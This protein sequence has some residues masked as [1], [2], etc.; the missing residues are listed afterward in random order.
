MFEGPE[1]LPPTRV[2]RSSAGEAERGRRE[3]AQVDSQGKGFQVVEALQMS[4]ANGESRHERTRAARIERAWV[5]APC[6]EESADIAY[7]LRCESCALTSFLSRVEPVECLPWWQCQ[8][9]ST[10]PLNRFLSAV[11]STVDC[12]HQRSTVQSSAAQRSAVWQSTVWHSA[13]Q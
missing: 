3:H 4:P 1:T 2:K 10:S 9:P 13:V 8:G 7:Q 12:P 6:V 5:T 11:Q